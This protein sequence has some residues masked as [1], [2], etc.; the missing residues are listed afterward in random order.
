M[1]AERLREQLIEDLGRLNV[2]IRRVAAGERELKWERDRL[3]EAT[4][5]IMVIW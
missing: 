3:T 4:E 5:I 1:D 2:L